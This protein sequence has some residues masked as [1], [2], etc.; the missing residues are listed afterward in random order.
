MHDFCHLHINL[1]MYSTCTMQPHDT[2][3][4]IHIIMPVAGMY[5][6]EMLIT[7]S[8]MPVTCM[9]IQKFLQYGPEWFGPSILCSPRSTTPVYS[10][11]NCTCAS[12]NR[13]ELQGDWDLFYP[14]LFVIPDIILSLSYN[15]S[16]A[17]SCIYMSYCLLLCN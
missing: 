4:Y 12:L 2:G 11:R 1:F 16:L 15:L 8:K 9:Y 6:Y 10:S 17:C 14:S 5:I 7:S 3:M 13:E